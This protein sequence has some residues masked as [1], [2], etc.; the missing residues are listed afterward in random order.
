MWKAAVWTQQ[1][2][3][4]A[5]IHLKNKQKAIKPRTKLEVLETQSIKQHDKGKIRAT[6]N[7]EKMDDDT[8]VTARI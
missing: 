8:V 1:I 5:S 7:L 3:V 4:I 6:T 2:I